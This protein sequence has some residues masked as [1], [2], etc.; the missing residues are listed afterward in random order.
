MANNAMKVETNDLKNCAKAYE[1]LAEQYKDDLVAVGN[2]L[3]ECQNY[4]Q[5]SFASDFDA[6]I[7]DIN[8]VR[9]AVYD[10]T[11]QLAKFLKEAAELYE[12]YDGNIARALQ[13]NPAL[14]AADYP[15]GVVPSV[16]VLSESELRNVCEGSK[17]RAKAESEFP[18]WYND[19]PTNS[20]PSCAWLTKRKA[21][22]YGFKGVNESWGG[23]GKD[24][25]R[26]I[27]LETYDFR[28]TKYSGDDCLQ[29]MLDAEGLP[30]RDI[31]VSFPKGPG[32]PY[33]EWGHVMYIDQI[34]ELDD[35]TRMVYYSDNNRIDTLQM[36]TV[37]E[38]LNWYNI[39]GQNGAPSGC[40]HL[41]KKV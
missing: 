23:D 35:G 27:P 29:Q 13:D 33:G 17:S 34:V 9:V 40:A 36:K 30:I 2:Q 21:E 5:G 15:D 16:Y 20:V 11:T 41:K 4:W 22:Q 38:F 31:I 6:I 10:D 39:V 24:V 8:K 19:P 7:D 28:A 18:I 14:K 26:N 25:V 37:D 1:K 32:D 3:S 12:K